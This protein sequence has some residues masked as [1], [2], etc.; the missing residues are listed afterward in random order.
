MGALE[1]TVVSTAMPTVIGELGGIHYYAWVTNAYLLTSSVTVPIYGKLADLYGR[2]PVLFFGIGVFLSGS[3]LCGLAWNM[4]TLIV[5]RGIQGIG[6]GAIIP[7]VT[8]IAADIYTLEERGKIQGYISSVWGIASVIGP[9]LGGVFAQYASWRWIFYLNLPI[10]AAAFI[11]LRRSLREDVLRQAH[12]IDYTG[13]TVLTIG[14][15]LAILG[16]LEGGVAWS[17]TSVTSIGLFA[18]AAVMLAVFARIERHAVE[19]ILPPW[20]FSRRVL[21]TAN[22]A[23]VAIGATV[24]GLSS[25]VPL[26]AQGVVGVGAVLAGFAMA[27]MSVGWPLASSQAARLYLRIDFRNTALIGSVFSIAGT[28]MFAFWVHEHS[29]L[30]RVALASFVTGVGLGFASISL[31]VAVQS[32]VEWDRRGVVTGA[33]MFC[34]SV[35][36]ALG[37]AVLGSIANTTLGD[38]FRNPPSELSGR[39]PHSVDTAT[40]A[41]SGKSDDVAV[42]QYTQDALYAAMHN[43]FLALL[44]VAVLGLVMQLLLP[45]R[46]RPIVFADDKPGG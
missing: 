23:G 7:M 39:L 30:G 25:Y 2:R 10:G 19:P 3:V 22:V 32:V 12:R 21:V 46:F 20:V 1:A 43:V 41:F 24:V 15:S 45:R 27:A 8:T 31:L 35:G 33:A 5:F 37:I 36:S 44:V 42:V 40:L 29:G 18:A 13:T 26:Y 11:V 28:V 9:A 38:W 16:L 14:L 4:T 6:A 34:R 17:W